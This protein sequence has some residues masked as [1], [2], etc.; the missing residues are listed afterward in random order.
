ASGA[1]EGHH[2]I[3]EAAL[4]I[5]ADAGINQRKHSRKELVHAFM[6]VEVFDH[7][8]VFAG[9]RFEA[10]FAAGIRQTAAIKHEASAIARFILRL[11]A[12]KGKAEDAHNKILRFGS[13]AIE[14]FR[15]QHALKCFHER[16]QFDG[17][18]G[19]V[20]Q[21]AQV[22]Q[23]VGHALQEMSF[24]LV[25]AAKTVSAQGLQEADVDV[26]VVEV[27]ERIAVQIEKRGQPV[28]IRIQELLTEFRRQVG[29]GIEQQRSDVVLQCAFAATLVV[30]EE[31]L[32]I[33]QHHVAGLEIAVEKVVAGR[34]QKEI[35]KTAE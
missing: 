24:A 25:K 19:V 22:F 30:N 17:Q 5:I 31:W 27:Q 15:G 8:R 12:M 16:G 11:A 1:S 20:Q 13:E 4:L 32:P 33:A 18:F 14:L 23:G 10:L 7:R 26:G 28:E 29:F 34:T 6:L 35:G 21:P 3:L 9:D 2:Q